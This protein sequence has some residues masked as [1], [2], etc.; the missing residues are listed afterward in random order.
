MDILQLLQNMEIGGGELLSLVD[1]SSAAILSVELYLTLEKSREERN[2]KLF[3]LEGSM[4]GSASKEVELN[5][6][7]A[8]SEHIHNK[9]IFDAINEALNEC[10]PY[11]VKGEPMPW[12]QEARKNYS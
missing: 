9:A 7:I 5:S 6:I 1:N 4:S 2:E 11:G 3:A 8:E 12:S 10:R